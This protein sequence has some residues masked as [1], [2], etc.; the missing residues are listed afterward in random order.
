M[1][2]GG[3]PPR[4]TFT[5]IFLRFFPRSRSAATIASD[6]AKPFD[7]ELRVTEAECA[8][9]IRPW[10]STTSKNDSGAF[11]L[12]SRREKNDAHD[13]FATP[14]SCHQCSLHRHSHHP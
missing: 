11:G 4:G 8:R 12:P 10:P 13:A 3:H 9:G 14:L 6:E 7:L 2:R 5:Q 1:P